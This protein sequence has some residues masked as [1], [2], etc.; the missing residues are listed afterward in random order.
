MEG[1]RSPGKGESDRAREGRADGRY[2]SP[3]RATTTPPPRAPYAV[4]RRADPAVLRDPLYDIFGRQGC[5]L[6]FFL[7]QNSNWTGKLIFKFMYVD[8]QDRLKKIDFEPGKAL[9]GYRGRGN[10]LLNR[11][12]IGSRQDMFEKC[13]RRTI[14]AYV[15]NSRLRVLN[16]E[17]SRR[18]SSFYSREC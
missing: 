13:Q 2:L 3:R 17:L 4:S 11:Y 5:W 9:R 7:I 14:L 10:N 18:L 12:Q 15:Q 16:S 8:T 1:A 6:I